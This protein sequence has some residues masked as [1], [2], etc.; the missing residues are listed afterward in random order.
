MSP[1]IPHLANE[2]LSKFNEND[3]FKWPEI[4]KKY[5]VSNK[6]IIVIQINGKKRNT[7]T[8]ENDLSEIELIDLIKN[9][10]LI[11]KY[12]NDGELIKTVYIKDR[13]INFIMK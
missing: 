9:K 7:I 1:I 2:Y 13:L 12:L 3:N 8:I 10:E 6:K 11:S 4:D 5:L